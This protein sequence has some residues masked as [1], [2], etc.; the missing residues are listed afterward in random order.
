[1]AIVIKKIEK[2]I[3]NSK[4]KKKSNGI[5]LLF[6]IKLEFHLLTILEES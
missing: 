1:M 6:F 5:L 4:I 2:K 3:L